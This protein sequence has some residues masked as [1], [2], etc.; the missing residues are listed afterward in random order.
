MDVALDT[1]PYNGTTTTLEGLWMGVPLIAK[2]GNRHC[3]RVGMS[4][5]QA[6][7]MEDWIAHSDEEY[8]QKAVDIANN[9]DQLLKTKKNLRNQLLNSPLCDS[10]AFAQ[11][12]ET[13]L[14]SMWQ[15]WSAEKLAETS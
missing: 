11:K 7:G 2:E 8:I 10:K 5:M 12:F 15:K 4:L 3:A 9:R 6:L 14:K 1:F 13:A